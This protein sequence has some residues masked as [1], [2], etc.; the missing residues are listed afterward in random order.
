MAPFCFQHVTVR[1]SPS[2]LLRVPLLFLKASPEMDQ[3]Y[4]LGT[5]EFWA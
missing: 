2:Y 3:E 1:T 4:N 5:R